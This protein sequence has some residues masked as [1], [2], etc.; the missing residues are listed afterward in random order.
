MIR[1][2]LKLA[3]CVVAVGCGQ[4]TGTDAGTGGGTAQCL[5]VGVGGYPDGGAVGISKIDLTASPP[6]VT[7]KNDGPTTVNPSAWFWCFEFNYGLVG[8]GP[9][10]AGQSATYSV[11]GLSAV[12]SDMG[13]Y[14]C[15]TFG[16]ADCLEDFVEWN[17]TGI[18]RESLAVAKGIWSAGGVTADG[19]LLLFTGN[20]T[21]TGDRKPH[22]RNVG[23][24]SGCSY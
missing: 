17:G 23:A 21:M 7:I 16:S 14:S 4:M 12:S 22:W 10:D 20:K 19:G 2:F 6:T 1:N 13:L 11:A 18:G 24:D 15:A 9:I 3:V 8:G 5:T